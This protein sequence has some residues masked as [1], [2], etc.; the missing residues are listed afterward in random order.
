MSKSNDF[1]EI[2]CAPEEVAQL[3]SKGTVLEVLSTCS[4]LLEE[5]SRQVDQRKLINALDTFRRR[6][7]LLK[8]SVS[9]YPFMQGALTSCEMQ[10]KKLEELSESVGEA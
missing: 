4:D 3:R 7:T 6:H 5:A 10:M 1:A 9:H 2:K 8:S